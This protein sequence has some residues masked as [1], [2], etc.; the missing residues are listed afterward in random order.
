MKA[1]ISI[2][3]VLAAFSSVHADP[4]EQ[5]VKFGDEKWTTLEVKFD[6]A[7]ATA[8]LSSVYTGQVKK[9]KVLF[10]NDENLTPKYDTFKVTT[11]EGDSKEMAADDNVVGMFQFVN[12]Y[13]ETD[14]CEFTLTFP[15]SK[16]LKQRLSY[17][18]VS[19]ANFVPVGGEVK[20][21][22]SVVS[23]KDAK[24]PG[25]VDYMDQTDIGWTV[26]Y[27]KDAGTVT[28]KGTSKAYIDFDSACF[29][30]GVVIVK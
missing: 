20:N 19:A 14:K 24:D 22:G 29:D 8:Y 6:E 26:S 16:E 28:V 13:P 17:G 4:Y 27:D 11:I 25:Y 5:T 30:I 1:V 15:V 23:S 10:A 21:M 3:L 18:L 9:G 12:L 7:G 2:A